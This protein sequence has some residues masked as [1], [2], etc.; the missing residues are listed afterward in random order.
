M[1]FIVIKMF[2]PKRYH[3]R[4]LNTVAFGKRIACGFDGKLIQNNYVISRVKRFS[5]PAFCSWSRA[6]SFRIWFGKRKNVASTKILNLK[7]GG[8]N[9][10]FDFIPRLFTLL[11]FL[12]LYCS[13]KFFII[14]I[15]I[16]IIISLFHFG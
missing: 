11:T 6:F 9:S 12:C 8:K 5:S 4:P 16:I 10:Y 14:I 13:C 7:Y 3:E 2:T 15:I 1:F